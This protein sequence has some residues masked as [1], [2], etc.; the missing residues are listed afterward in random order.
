MN[1]KELKKKSK[2]LSLILRH[3]PET[4]GITLDDSGWVDVE[5]LLAA[6]SQQGKGMS[7]ATLDTVVQSNDKQRFSF[8]AEGTRI[9][10]NQGHSISVDLGYTTAVP[11]EILFHGTPDKF[12]EPISQE[13]LKKMNRHH[14]HLHVDEQ[15]SIAVGRRRGRPVLLQVR[16]LEMHQAGWEFFVTPNQVWLTDSVPVEYIEFP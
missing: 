1:E 13:G 8:N 10:A 2:F 11:P 12:I 6:M 7:R 15:T 9:R 16:A 4:V 5:V 3:Q 14:V